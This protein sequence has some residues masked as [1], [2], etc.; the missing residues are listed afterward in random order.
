[1]RTIDPGG[2]TAAPERG[3]DA[4]DIDLVLVGATGFTGGLVADD[5]AAR[6]VGM[7]LRWALAGRSRERLE[8]VAARLESAGGVVPELRVVDAHDD[9]ALAA[10]A[11][12]TRV[13]AT[14]VGPYAQHGVPL[15]RA[16]AEAGTHYA[17]ITGE[18]AFVARLRRELDDVARASGARLV[19]CCGFDSVP[20]DLG[21]RFAAAALPQGG[22]IELA[23]YVQARGGM[24]GG[25][26][27]SALG[28]IAGG[29][30]RGRRGR[31]APRKGSRNGAR[32][33]TR[34]ASTAVRE[35]TALPIGIH[36]VAAL[37]GWGLPLPTI[38]AAIVLESARRLEGYGSAFRYGH[39]ALVRRRRT[40]ALATA[41]LGLA[42]AAVRLAPTRAV[43]ARLL[44]SPGEGPDAEARERGRFRVTFL[45]RAGDVRVTARV[46]GGDPG[47]GETSRMLAEAALTLASGE[48]PEVAGVVTPSVG[49]GEPY[50]R[51]LEAR[52]MRFELLE[53]P[54]A[55]E[56]RGA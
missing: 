8:A 10:L 14:T 31:P 42:L 9:A 32:S 39:Y 13:V 24:S 37:G 33:G 55:G 54:E 6:L 45:G 4:R 52:G 17:D 1:M 56:G 41:G 46:S 38:D 15:A 26:A 20:H 53:G 5:L 18:P 36:R 47:Y 29:G 30:P 11:R 50:R 43:L 48:A 19:T 34:S 12:S 23:G 7:G 21:A 35:A 40:V 3:P 22:P 49:L 28:A 16:C 27:A 51:R 44:P 2:R 25:T